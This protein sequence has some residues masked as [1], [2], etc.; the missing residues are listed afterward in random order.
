MTDNSRRISILGESEMSQPATCAGKALAQGN[1][2]RG[3][4]ENLFEEAQCCQLVGA[5]PDGDCA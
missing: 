1:A 2:D 5:T 3:L 4:A